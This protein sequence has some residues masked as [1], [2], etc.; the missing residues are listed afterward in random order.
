MPKKIRAFTFPEML[1]SIT[2]AALLF[3]L[4]N[5][6]SYSVSDYSARLIEMS[7]SARKLEFCVELFRKELGELRRE[8]GNPSFDFL[9]GEGMLSYATSRLELIARS[10]IP[11]GFLR[12][13][14]MH[15]PEKKTLERI[16]TPVVTDLRL[17][18]KSTRTTLLTNV[19]K[20]E[21]SVFDEK[22]WFPLTGSL[23]PIQTA[24]AVDINIQFVREESP[25]FGAVF[26]TA[27][28]LPK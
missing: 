8:T 25:I 6:I 15:D 19:D 2:L 26:N 5:G 17:A 16:V 21:F 4:V 22:K 1:I 14:W 7:S 23:A 10:E 20:V 18:G 9:G 3:T 11:S 13:E 24:I 27:F 28:L 12:V